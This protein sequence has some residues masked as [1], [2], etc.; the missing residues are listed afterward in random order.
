MIDAITC[1]LGDAL[2]VGPDG[3]MHLSWGAQTHSEDKS[4]VEVWI[5]APMNLGHY[6]ELLTHLKRYLERCPD[7]HQFA[8][9]ADL[10]R[11]LAAYVFADGTVPGA[12]GASDPV[13]AVVTS[14]NSSLGFWNFL[15]DRL[16]TAVRSPAPMPSGCLHRRTDSITWKS[17][18]RMWAL[19]KDGQRLFAGF[20]AAPG[21][22]VVGPDES[23]RGI[24]FDALDRCELIE[25]M[26]G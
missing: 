5:R 16:G 10:E 12:L 22:I 1:H 4:R 26:P 25:V 6:P 11:T 21:G 2:F 3:R 17:D 15:I 14:P 23:F 7:D 8:Q 13:F 19:E 20:K 24:D 9:A 18:E